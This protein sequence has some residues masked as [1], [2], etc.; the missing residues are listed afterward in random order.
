MLKIDGMHLTESGSIFEYLEEN[1]ARTALMPSDPKARAEVRRLMHWFDDKFH[2]EV[3][4]NLVYERREQEDHARRLPGRESG[5]DTAR[6]RSSIT[7]I[8]WPGLLDHR[9]WLAGDAMTMADFTAAAH[10]SCLDYISD[11]DW[12]RSTWSRT[13]TPR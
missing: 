3:T 9:R 12:N 1:P 6:S 2:H 4:S 10:L 11:V 7:S 13:G 8:T 5:E